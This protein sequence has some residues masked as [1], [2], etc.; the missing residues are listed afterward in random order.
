MLVPSL[1]VACLP[2]K[3]EE[4]WSLQLAFAPKFAGLVMEVEHVLL[5][6]LNFSHWP[7]CK[8]Y[9]AEKAGAFRRLFLF[10]IYIYLF[11]LMNYFYIN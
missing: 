10:F 9:E 7:H 6:L 11:T 2:L 1:S 4:A 3:V 8:G 5:A